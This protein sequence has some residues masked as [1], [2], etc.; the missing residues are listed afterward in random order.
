MSR[1]RAEAVPGLLLVDKPIGPTSHDM[2]QAARRVLGTRRIGHTGTLDPFAS[3]LLL[4][5]VG[6]MTRLVEYFHALTKVY[7]ADL[8]LGEETDTYDPTGE[9]TARSDSWREVTATGI[10][11]ALGRFT[12]DIH[13]RPPEYSAKKVGGERSYQAARAGRSVELEPVPV[14]VYEL[15]LE[16]FDPPRAR[17]RT[18]VST[19]TYVRALGRDL[20]RALGCGAHLTGLRRTAV[21]PFR[22][23]SAIQGAALAEDIPRTDPHWLP[24]ARAVDWLQLREIDERELTLVRSGR[25]IERKR[26][27]DGSAGPDEVPEVTNLP[28]AL[29]AHG[30]L[31]AVAER[32]GDDLQPRKVLADG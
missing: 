23:E 32:E 9:V 14:R 18:R 17:I 26:V 4:L 12:G 7:V 5:A 6:S 10:E 8:L 22:V 21:G 11:A 29:V 28:V 24:P 27:V 2:V 31:V 19:G 15:G 25:R 3:G 13:Q 16:A 30:R 20:G 1:T